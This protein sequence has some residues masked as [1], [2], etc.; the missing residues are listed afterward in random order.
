MAISP[1]AEIHFATKTKLLDWFRK[2][3]PG[4]DTEYI[5][6][7]KMLRESGF[8]GAF[9][10]LGKE[11]G[12]PIENFLSFLTELNLANLLLSKGVTDL[13]YEPKPGQ[14]IDFSFA[15]IDLSAKN[16]GT[17][18]Y[19]RKEN[20]EIEK[21]KSAGGGKQSLTHKNFS[22]IFLEVEKNSMGTFTYSRLETGH[23]GFLDS[24]MAQLSVVLE[25]I[26]KFESKIKSDGRKKVLFFLS[27]TADFNHYHALD[28]AY[29]YFNVHPDGY[30]FIFN[31]DPAQ[32]LKL[33]K[34][35]AKLNNIDALVFV[36]PPRPLIWPLGSLAD[37]V[38]ERKRTLIYTDDKDLW[39]RLPEIFS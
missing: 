6:K 28:I 2:N 26:G 23:S 5:A 4:S 3:I 9:R 29:W 11:A 39:E 7:K 16:L 8:S 13:S 33:M 10:L 1:N 35:D 30:H 17:K 14:D 27:H 34:R 21:L 38:Q 31:N 32:Y 15:D 18:N 24:D 37:V 20:L 12:E 36:F 22:D 25:N 19:E